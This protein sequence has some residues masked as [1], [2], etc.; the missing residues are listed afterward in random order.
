MKSMGKVSRK[1]HYKRI[2]AW[3]Y[4]TPSV[5]LI[6]FF[7]WLSILLNDWTVIERSGGLIALLGA[8][9]GLRKLLRKGARELE[10][11]N[12]PLWS[13]PEFNGAR[14]FNPNGMWQEVE[15]L[16]DSFAQQLGL[17]LVVIGTLISSFGSLIMQLL[18]PLGP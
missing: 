7:G 4:I 5:I 8:L 12:E 16:S 10:T 17:I 1:A 13:R 11:P 6:I 2:K 9:L 15:D 18:F 14:Q 3:R